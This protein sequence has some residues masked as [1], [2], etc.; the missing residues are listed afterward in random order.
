MADLSS[1]AINECIMRFARRAERVDREKLVA[2]FVSN[3]PFLAILSTEDNQII[4]GRRGTGKTHAL[5]YLA[6]DVSSRSDIS[7]YVDMRTIGS[8]GSVYA[9][10]AQSMAE[11]ATRLLVDVLGSVHDELLSLSIDKA[12]E[13]DLS[14]TGPRLDRLA[15][16][17]SQVKVVGRVALESRDEAS[18]SRASESRFSLHGDSAGVSAGAASRDETRNQ[19]STAKRRTEEGNERL[20]VHF[21][22]VGRVLSDLVGCFEGRRFWF[23]LDE[24]SAIPLNLQPYLANLLRRAIFPVGNITVK[25]AAIEHRSNLQI[26]GYDNDYVGIEIGADA[27]ANLNLDDFMVFDNDQHR[28]KAFFQD[29]LFKHFRA[30]ENL[31][32]EDGPQTAAE[33]VRRAFTQI[34]AFEELVRAVEGVP[35]DAIN[36]AEIAAQRA[37]AVPISVPH[38]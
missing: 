28:A 30:S 33:F 7:I 32:P 19:I 12:N 8:D 16:A 24:W 14:H 2:T 6:D 3:G 35:R 29:L 18:V 38:I 9:D 37:Y 34:T 31:A 11:R 23:L 21:G 20:T 22:T 1:Q 10:E 27:Q 4:Y 5:Q 36:I 15:E 13:F 17:I 25:I 26:H